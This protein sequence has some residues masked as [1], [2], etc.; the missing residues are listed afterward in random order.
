MG[1]WIGILLLKKLKS[2]IAFIGIAAAYNFTENKMWNNF[3]FKIKK[4]Y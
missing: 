1:G 4:E 2:V 3:S